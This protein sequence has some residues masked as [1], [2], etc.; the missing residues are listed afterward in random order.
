MNERNRLTAHSIQHTMLIPLY[1]R[2]AAGRRFPEILRDH[3][4][5]RIMAETKADL[6]GIRTVYDSEYRIA[7]QTALAFNGH[8]RHGVSFSF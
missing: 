1:S 7:R 5:E 3:T 4:A 6:K 2:A 8:F